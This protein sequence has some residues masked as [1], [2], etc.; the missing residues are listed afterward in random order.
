VSGTFETGPGAPLVASRTVPHDG[1][2]R[3]V[4]AGASI[5]AWT[6][7]LGRAA[8]TEGLLDALLDARRQPRGHYLRLWRERKAGAAARE[9]G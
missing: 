2:R 5:G 8:D 7:V 3:V 4:I 9:A 6:G 1:S